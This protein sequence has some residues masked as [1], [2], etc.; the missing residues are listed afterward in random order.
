MAARR[1]VEQHLSRE[2]RKEVA[3]FARKLAK[4]YR[5]QFT[6]DTNLRKRAGQFLAALLPPKPRR[7]GRPGLPSVTTAI[8]LLRQFRRQYPKDSGGKIW[9]RIY[10]QAIPDYASLS[11]LEQADAR[12]ELRERVR[13]RQ[14]AKKRRLCDGRR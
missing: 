12:Q 1:I 13:W 4:G 9:E 10:P 3:Q 7:R 2:I 11:E 8:R 14:R 6:S 5:S